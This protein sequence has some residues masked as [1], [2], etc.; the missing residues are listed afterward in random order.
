MTVKEASTFLA[1]DEGTLARMAEARQI[2]AVKVEN[3]WLFS[4]KSL[5]KW[6]TLQARRAGRS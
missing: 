2:P 4:K 1:L 3:Q 5:Q 6:Q